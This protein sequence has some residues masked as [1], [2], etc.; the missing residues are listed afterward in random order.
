MLVHLVFIFNSSQLRL[1]TDAASV[2]Y[3]VACLATH[4]TLICDAARLFIQQSP[5]LRRKNRDCRIHLSQR[6]CH[7]PSRL[8]PMSRECC[9]SQAFS[10][11]R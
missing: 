8:G 2:H 3:F 5:S 6:D 4:I 11:A 10:R 9:G 7:R 1:W